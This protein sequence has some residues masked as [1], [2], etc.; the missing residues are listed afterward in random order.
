MK[1][2]MAPKVHLKFLDHQPVETR[3]RKRNKQRLVKP[4]GTELDKPE[5]ILASI[6]VIVMEMMTS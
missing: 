1:M 5:M 2:R 3:K 6:Q 4:T